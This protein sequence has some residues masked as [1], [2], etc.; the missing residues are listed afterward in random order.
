MDHEYICA[1]PD[2][3]IP[4]HS[5]INKYTD[6]VLERGW[7]AI[8]T[9]VANKKLKSGKPVVDRDYFWRVLRKHG[10]WSVFSHPEQIDVNYSWKWSGR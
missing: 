6:E 3:D 7:K 1:I 2:R 9:V 8:L 10:I 4:E 5:R